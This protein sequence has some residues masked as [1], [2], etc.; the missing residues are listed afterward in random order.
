MKRNLLIAIMM[1][2]LVGMVNAESDS[3]V[4]NI[5]A[6]FDIAFGDAADPNENYGAVAAYNLDHNFFSSRIFIRATDVDD[7]LGPISSGL[8][9]D[10]VIA[11]IKTSSNSFIDN[12]DNYDVT[13]YPLTQVWTEGT[14]T[15]TS[16]PNDLTY[17]NYT[18]ATAWSTLGGD[19]GPAFSNFGATVTMLIDFSTTD[20]VYKRYYI[21][22]SYFR[23]MVEEDNTKGWAYVATRGTGA[24]NIAFAVHTDDAGEGNRPY[25]V[26]Y[27][28]E[29]ASSSARRRRSQQW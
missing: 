20:E 3:T 21:D 2:L 27:H 14:G 16:D 7:V 24:P 11:F 26:A 1:L 18:T 28:T 22:T 12:G 25:V 15:G 19:F 13:G 8:D 10:S 29:K 9:Y 6:N 4:F 5:Q 17:T 23:S